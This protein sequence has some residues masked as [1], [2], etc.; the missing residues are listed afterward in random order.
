MSYNY[1]DSKFKKNLLN[2][3][4]QYYREYK[5]SF[6][7]LIELLEKNILKNLYINVI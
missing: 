3:N 5:Y 7:D 4:S 1:L 2:H 6:G